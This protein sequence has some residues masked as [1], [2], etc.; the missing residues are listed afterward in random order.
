MTAVCPVDPKH[1]AFRASGSGEIACVDCQAISKAKR[2]NKYGAVKVETP[3]G[4][5]DSKKEGRRLCDLQMMERAGEITDLHAHPQFDLIAWSPNGPKVIGKYTADAGYRRDGRI[6][7]E[8]VKSE[9]TRKRGDY[10]LRRR[11]FM[12]NNPHI[13]F[14]ET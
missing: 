5:A 11:I 1:R 3:L 8:D 2:A 4:M 7:V 6:V 14:R 10:S 9:I 13:D 12:A